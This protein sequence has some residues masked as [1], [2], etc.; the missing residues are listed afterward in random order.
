[1]K[2]LWSEWAALT[3]KI[4]NSENKLLFLDFDGTLAPIKKHPRSVSLHK[5][6]KDVIGRISRSNFY[7]VMIISGR[8][9]NDLLPR[10][11]LRNISYI[12]NH[13]LE[14]KGKGLRLPSKARRARKLEVLIWLLGE[15]LNEDFSDMPGILIEDKNYTLS[16]H[17]RNIPRRLMTIFRSRAKEFRK[18][19]EHWPLIWKKGKKIWD[20]RP[21]VRWDKGDA[22]SYLINRY[23]GFLPIAIGDDVTDED[24]FRAVKHKGIGIRVGRRKK[25]QAEYY[26]S[27][28]REV[29]TFLEKLSEAGVHSS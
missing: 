10:F 23:P 21:G 25:S 8:P 4:S 15:K 9:L 5:K 3:N 26:L 2:Y 16:F 12:G 20:I 18:K 28:P 22:V 1:M 13:G 7:K 19:F 6:T 17:Y 11:G 27:S 14:V 29:R 24:M